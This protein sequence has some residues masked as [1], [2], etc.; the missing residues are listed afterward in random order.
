MN[1][2]D[3]SVFLRKKEFCGIFCVKV[4]KFFILFYFIIFRQLGSKV[5]PTNLNPPVRFEEEEEEEVEEEDYVD[6]IKLYGGLDNDGS[7]KACKKK[8]IVLLFI[9]V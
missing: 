5:D 3:C 2:K 8:K 4:C 7:C 6:M 9:C 1:Y